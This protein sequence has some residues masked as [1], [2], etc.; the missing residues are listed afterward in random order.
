MID[1]DTALLGFIAVGLLVIGVAF[2]ALFAIV[3]EMACRRFDRLE[4]RIEA[5]EGPQEDA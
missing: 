3:K 5:L 4:K 1:T 2:A